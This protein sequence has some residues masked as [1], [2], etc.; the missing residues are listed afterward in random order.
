MGLSQSLASLIPPKDGVWDVVF[1]LAPESRRRLMKF[2]QESVGQIAQDF[3]RKI[4]EP[5]THIQKKVMCEAAE[6]F[7]QTKIRE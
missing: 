6:V 2:V 1:E 3:E 5:P 4:R 7:R